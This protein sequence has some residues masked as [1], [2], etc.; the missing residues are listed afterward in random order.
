MASSLK[1]VYEKTGEYEAFYTG[2]DI[3]WTTDG[4]QFLC[5]CDDVIK[6]IDVNTLCNTLTIGV[7]TDDKDGTDQIYT[8]NMSHDNQTVIT[9]HKSGLIKLWD[10]DSGRQVKVWKSG[11]KGAVARL[12]FDSND[13]NVASG[14]TDGNVR[15][16]D[17]THHT[18]TSSLKGAMGVFTVLKYHPDSS[19]QLI[20][21]AADDTKIRSWD[22]KTGKDSIVY[23]GHFSKVTSLQFTLD[24]EHMVSS[25]RDRVLILWKI[26]ESKALRVVP[27]YECIETIILMPPTFKVPNFKKKLETEGIYVACAGEKGA[28]KIWNVQISRLMF[29]QSNSLV[30]PSTEEGGLAVTHL[31]YNEARNMLSIATADHNIIIHDLETFTCVKQMIGFT[32]EILDIIFVGKDE[33]HIVV[34]TNSRDL[35]HYELGT[36]NCKLIKGHTDIVLALANFPTKPNVFVSSGKDNSV[37][38][39]FQDEQNEIK[40]FGIGVRHTGSVGSVFTSQTSD[41]FFTSVSQDNC[42]KLWTVPEEVDNIDQKI[43]S[44]HTE[45]AHNMDINCVAVSPNDKI[46]ATGSQDKT[47]K[48]WTEDLSLLGIL[49]GHRRGIWCVRFSS[50]DQVVLTSSADSTLKLWSIADL[51]CLKT[52]EGHESSVL[53][54]E[55]LSKGQ[56]IISSGADGLLKLWNIK[57]SECKMS[58]DNHDGKVWSLAVNKN[59]SVIITGGS[60]SKLVTLKDV[61][62]EKRE[63]SAKEREALILQE[64]ELLNL[65]HDKKLVK[66]LKLA[67]RMERP[68]HVLKIVNEVL[69]Y[70][71]DKLS[72]TLK[73]INNTQ[74]ETLL[75]FAAEWNTNNKNCHAAQLVFYVLAPEII[76]GNLKVSSLASLVEGTLPYTER[77]FERLT[78]LLQDLNFISYTVNCMQPH[79]VKNVE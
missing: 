40:C 35:K 66:A 26:G 27:V 64:Q 22:S 73:E 70:G 69:K 39:W 68:L 3:Q 7:S 41:R 2:G 75:R 10:K 16:W 47:A 23:A 21:G 51:S 44:S 38:I 33:T 54:I 34:A 25:G 79:A 4:G 5:Q 76:S 59:E 17:I 45:L 1:E 50:V 8:F 63:I 19:K 77:H 65:L 36:M 46:I 9:A 12:A 13:T 53:K 15:L 78:N 52:F 14:G 67:I 43:K 20:F 31:L 61:S 6:V 37:R 11:H 57:S 58:L 30:S 60:D 56:Q 55:F 71:K 29:E 24:G 72:D 42:L 28:V 49:K 74:K 48:L 18:C 32:D 62:M